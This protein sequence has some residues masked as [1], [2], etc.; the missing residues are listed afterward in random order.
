MKGRNHA[1]EGQIGTATGC[2][3]STVQCTPGLGAGHGS[4]NSVCVVRLKQ[5]VI[6]TFLQVVT[7]E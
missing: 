6:A 5:T 7:K 3:I 4:L 2:Y 1:T